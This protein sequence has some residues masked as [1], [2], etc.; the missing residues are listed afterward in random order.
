MLAQDFSKHGVRDLH[1]S[2]C[3]KGCAEP[4]RALPT[5]LPKADS[6]DLVARGLAW[7]EPDRRDLDFDTLIK[8]LEQPNAV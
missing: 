4:R 2:G 3:A 7:D 5:I 8:I 1:I 6:F